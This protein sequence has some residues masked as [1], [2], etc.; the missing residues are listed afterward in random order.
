M[1]IVIVYC[2]SIICYVDYI[3]VFEYGCIVEEGIYDELFG[4]VGFYMCMFVVDGGS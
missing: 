2:L 1:K 4:C 3:V